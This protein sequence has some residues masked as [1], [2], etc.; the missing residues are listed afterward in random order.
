MK[1]EKRHEKEAIVTAASTRS[2]QETEEIELGFSSFFYVFQRI[3]QH[4][5]RWLARKSKNPKQLAINSN[6]IVWSVRERPSIV[7]TSYERY[8]F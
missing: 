1:W 5:Q 8:Q 4:D 3:W 6:L 2:F 7:V